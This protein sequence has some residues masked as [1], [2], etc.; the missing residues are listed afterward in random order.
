MFC[1]YSLFFLKEGVILKKKIISLILALSILIC[2]VSVKVERVDAAAITVG[3]MT[4]AEFLFSLG[5]SCVSTYLVYDAISAKDIDDELQKQVDYYMSNDSTAKELDD[6]QVDLSTKSGRATQRILQY[7]NNNRNSN[8][9]FP[10]KYTSIFLSAKLSKALYSILY[11]LKNKIESLGVADFKSTSFCDFF[12]NEDFS[13]NVMYKNAFLHSADDF[14]TLINK[15]V[16]CD[17]FYD[18]F[19]DYKPFLIRRSDMVYSSSADKK[20]WITPYRTYLKNTVFDNSGIELVFNYHFNRALV[21]EIS[22]AKGI[23]SY[24]GSGYGVKFVN[25]DKNFFS[26]YLVHRYAN[27]DL[28]IDFYDCNNDNKYKIFSGSECLNGDGS[29]FNFSSDFSYIF[30]NF[31][32][33]EY[34]F[35]S[36][37]K[38]MEKFNKNSKQFEPVT[39]S[40]YSNPYRLDNFGNVN[41]DYST[42]INKV[43]KKIEPKRK[44]QEVP[45]PSTGEKVKKEVIEIPS[46]DYSTL[47]KLNNEIIPE[48]QKKPASEG[49]SRADNVMESIGKN[50]DSAVLVDTAGNPQTV[51][52]VDTVDKSDVKNNFNNNQVYGNADL[53]DIFPFCIPFDFTNIIKKLNATPEAP[54]FEV[55][56]YTLNKN[57]SIK[58]LDK[59]LVIDLSNFD[60]VATAVRKFEL[61]ILIVGLIFVS[62]KL[63]GGGKT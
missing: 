43:I 27:P 40:A 62:Y 3:G 36:N 13:D 37:T 44:I 12:Y 7:P 31:N 49:A 24:S 23:T 30:H 25:L 41:Y 61:L 5:M 60:I 22:G 58:K 1:I 38:C 9:Q 15:S 8:N 6:E 59:G 55:P 18:N 29:Y 48:I 51:T 35:N 28:H 50:A 26:N 32:G 39:Q 47:E 16:G 54:K 52:I 17:Y 4:V 10:G 46:Y 14:Q 2:S 57:M 34:R 20:C 63:I 53:T 56:M 42:T 19:K 11:D 33:T 21:Y 45:D